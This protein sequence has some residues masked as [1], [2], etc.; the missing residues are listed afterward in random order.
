MRLTSGKKIRL[1]L[2]IIIGISLFGSAVYII[3]KQENLIGKN[4]V[5]YGIFKDVNGLNVGNNVRYSGVNVGTVSGLKIINDTS[6]R[7]KATLENKV[8]QFIR[9]DSKMEIGTEGVMGSKIL[10]ITPGNPS[11]LTVKKQGQLQT[12]EPVEADEII[13][14]L[15]K[16]SVHTSKF[17]ENLAN[18]SGKINRGKG[19]IGNLITDTSLNNNLSKISNNTA[20]LTHEFN[21]IAKKINKEIIDR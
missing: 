8:H 5:V 6:V 10:K 19:I 16:S 12:T 11:V 9:Q 15:G 20:R 17:A 7:V 1:W 21:L 13:E 2:F 18:I 4:F 14:E 3:G